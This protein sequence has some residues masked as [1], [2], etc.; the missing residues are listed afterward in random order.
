MQRPPI[1]PLKKE[2]KKTR[3]P[4]TSERQSCEQE[5]PRHLEPERRMR[6]NALLAPIK[7]P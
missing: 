4:P 2:K 1:P 6:Q 7:D 3:I 5:R